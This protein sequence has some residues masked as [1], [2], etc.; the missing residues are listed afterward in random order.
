MYPIYLTDPLLMDMQLVST[1]SRAEILK[2]CHPHNPERKRTIKSQETRV[3][4]GTGG[5]KEG[6]RGSAQGEEEVLSQDTPE[7][8]SHLSPQDV[9]AAW[10]PLW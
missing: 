7:L 9:G 10:R 1:F 3:L 8:A 5:Q 2:P 6:Q 4:V